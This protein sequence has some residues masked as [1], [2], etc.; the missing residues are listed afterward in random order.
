[1]S[2]DGGVASSAC[3]VLVLAV[4]NVKMGLGVPVLLREAEINDVNLVT[5]L[6]NTHQEVIRF[7]VTMN[8]V[9]GMD[10]FDTRNLIQLLAAINDRLTQISRTS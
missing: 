6:A 5:P 9:A 3:E 7:N 10:V 2:V 1:M 4:R 8:E